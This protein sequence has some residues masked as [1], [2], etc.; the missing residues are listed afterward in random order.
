MKADNFYDIQDAKSN[1]INPIVK[2]DN[3]FQKHL[4]QVP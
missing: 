4:K 2:A 1:I 3:D